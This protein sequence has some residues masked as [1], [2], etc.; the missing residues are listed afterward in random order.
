MNKFFGVGVS[1]FVFIIN[2]CLVLNF[3]RNYNFCKIIFVEIGNIF[4]KFIYNN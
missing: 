1:C 4:Y 3:E 2:R